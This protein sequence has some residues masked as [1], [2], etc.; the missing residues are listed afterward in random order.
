M[1]SF[2]FNVDASSLCDRATFLGKPCPVPRSPGVYAWYF[3][4]A[5]P[6]IDIADCHVV[7]GLTLLYVGIAPG[8]RITRGK[9][10]RRTLQD[11]LGDHYCGNAEGSTLRLSLGC[12]LGM[13]LRRVGSGAT[14]TFTNPGE[15]E[16]DAWMSENA[17]VTWL[18]V[19]RPWE[20]EHAILQSGCPLPLNGSGNPNAVLKDFIEGVRKRAKDAAIAR[21][22]ADR[23]GP[24]WGRRPLGPPTDA[25]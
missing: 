19:E 8:K 25:R 24:R 7:D 21:E 15:Q 14:R 6:E 23:G 17:F 11:R 9:P 1:T 2:P 16:L 18:E 4:K 12:L 13:Q 22:I 3:A 10:S 20:M 5:P